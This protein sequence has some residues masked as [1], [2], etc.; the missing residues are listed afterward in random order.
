MQR[1]IRNAVLAVV[2]LPLLVACG[3][4]EAATGRDVE[5][6]FPGQRGTLESARIA[7]PAGTREVKLE[8]ID[9]Q[10]VLEGDILLAP[11]QVLEVEGEPQRHAQGAA[12]QGSV[13]WPE[14]VIPYVFRSDLPAATQQEVHAAIAHWHQHTSIR[15]VARTTEPDYV[16]FQPGSGCSS[17]LGR[18]G[19]AQTINL[20]D[21]CST[22]NTI[23]E[24]GHAVGLFHE[25]SRVDRDS[26]V[27]IQWANIDPNYV[28]NFETYRQQGWT[29]YWE[30]SDLGGYDLGSIMH[31]PSRSFSIN[32]QATIL[33][34][35][36]GWIEG[37]RVG[38]SA[39]DIAAVRELYEGSTPAVVRL[40]ATRMA[41]VVRRADTNLY[42]SEWDG[43][44]WSAEVSLGGFARSS[45]AIASWGP[46]RVD[47]FT[48][49]IDR[50][51]WH[52]ARQ[53]STWSGWTSLGGQ[54]TSAPA[55]VSWG[56]NRVDVVVRGTDNAAW[57]RAWTGSQWTPWA[58]LS[59]QLTAAPALSSRGAN[60]LD[61][62]VR[63]TDNAL[64]QKVW[65]G[66]GWSNWYGLGGQLASA[67]TAVSWGPS[68]IDV[69][70]RATDGSVQ[71]L[72][73]TGTGWY[74]WF[75]LGGSVTGAPAATSRG[76]NQLDVLV[77]GVGGNLSQQSWTGSVWTGWF[78]LGSGMY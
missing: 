45:P 55:A 57:H 43:S 5:Q 24:I 59:G 37:Q 39:G 17:Y 51:L 76:V 38:L 19:G 13:R 31:Y 49:G 36:G 70:S 28:H 27:T 20:A 16:V 72:V 44:A 62:F 8:R 47:V 40:D 11:G 60:H 58:G 4:E 71:Q 61:V 25:Q 50:A 23:H 34:K 78:G 42:Y 41:R 68:R 22:G 54:L 77:R 53:G 56:P 15:L 18:T 7:T 74:G 52:N 33:T 69:F 35:T 12:V 3:V 6:A 30:G 46:D 66:T 14:G 10:R 2:C 73:W 9:G 26:H 65:T 64:H 21:G 48:M 67:P 75:N 1:R 29:G 63:G 32:G